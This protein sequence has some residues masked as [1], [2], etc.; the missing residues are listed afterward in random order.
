M[1]NQPNILIVDSG[2][3]K[4]SWCLGN[5]HQLLFQKETEGIQPF[6]LTDTQIE[7][8]IHQ[9]FT[10][11]PE[12]VHQL[13]FYG[14][15]C[16]TQQNKDRLKA[17][18]QSFFP[19]T[20]IEIATD[21]LAAARACCQ[22]QPGIAAIL[23]TGSNVCRYDGQQVVEYA[24]GNGYVL[25]DEGS[26][27]DIG[28]ALLKAY[29]E[30]R[31]PLSLK[32]A[33]ES[34]HVV[35]RATILH[36]VYQGPFPNRYMSTFAP[37]LSQHLDAPFVQQLLRERFGQFYQLDVLQ[38]KHAQQLPVHFVGSVAF[39]FRHILRKLGKEYQLDIGTIIRQPID[40]L[41]KYHGLA[42]AT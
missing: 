4:A 10:L 15:G 21:V 41:V 19:A 18:F 35:D 12:P 17:V 13:F 1:K 30:K 32:Q 8:Y 23:G 7:N 14:T 28:K 20:Q 31:L 11:I 39:H 5:A 29:L 36:E 33:L 42:K 27:A 16:N 22:Q 37:F 25:G 40:G 34:S 24:G 3:T 6:F 2:A 9:V 26:G 38:L